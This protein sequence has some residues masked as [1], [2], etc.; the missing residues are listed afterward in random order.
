MRSAGP[1]DLR[2]DGRR[3]WAERCGQCSRTRASLHA[4]TRSN[5]RW[6]LT[7]G[8]V[9]VYTQAISRCRWVVGCLCC[10]RGSASMRP[11][12]AA[13]SSLSSIVVARAPGRFCWRP[14]RLWPL[15]LLRVGDGAGTGPRIRVFPRGRALGLPLAGSSQAVAPYSRRPLPAA[16][17]AQ[18]INRPTS[19]ATTPLGS[20]ALRPRRERPILWYMA[21]PGWPTHRTAQ[22]PIQAAPMR[23]GGGACE[24][25]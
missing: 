9:R 10:R 25:S 17:P 19:E 13:L 23:M 2:G 1:V 4:L 14:Q 12:M 24:L 18:V 16:T 21:G 8:G 5:G 6:R 11:T 15:H 20:R 22:L 7:R 3:R